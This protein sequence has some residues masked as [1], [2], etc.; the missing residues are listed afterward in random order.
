[1]YINLCYF[2]VVYIYLFFFIF[3]DTF[4]DF[5]KPNKMYE[6]KIVELKLMGVQIRWTYVVF[7]NKIY[8]IFLNCCPLG[9]CPDINQSKPLKIK[10]QKNIYLKYI[11]VI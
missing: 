1:M 10:L 8:I 2:Y 5:V 3:S 6:L 4:E 7:E 11:L 9:S